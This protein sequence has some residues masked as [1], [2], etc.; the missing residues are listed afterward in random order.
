MGRLSC[1]VSAKLFFLQVSSRL[2]G[3]L[4]NVRS[5][6]RSLEA[7]FCETLDPYAGRRLGICH[8]RGTSMLV[9]IQNVQPFPESI[10]ASVEDLGGA[11]LLDTDSVSSSYLR[12]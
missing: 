2:E 12:L 11:G 9:G 10:F 6:R 8:L 7:D 4:R 5:H 3:F 1:L